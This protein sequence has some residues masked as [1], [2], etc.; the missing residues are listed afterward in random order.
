MPSSCCGSRFT[1]TIVSI[2]AHIKDLR[3]FKVVLKR[4]QVLTSLQASVRLT[5]TLGLSTPC[6]HQAVNA[7][8]ILLSS[9]VKGSVLPLNYPNKGAGFEPATLRLPVSP[10]QHIVGSGTRTHK[11]V[12]SQTYEYNGC[13]ESIQPV[14]TTALECFIETPPWFPW[15]LYSSCNHASISC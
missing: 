14:S 2:T 8:F 9:T 5:N 15:P 7:G 13:R 3:L 4:S 1:P 10:S 6:T 11:A 12:A